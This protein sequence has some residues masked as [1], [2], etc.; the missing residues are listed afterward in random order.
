MLQEKERAVI[1]AGSACTKAAIVAKRPGFILDKALLL[2]PLHAEWRIGQHIIKS[3]FGKTVIFKGAVGFDVI[4]IF[5]FDEHVRTADGISFVVP[6]LPE[7]MRLGITIEVADVLLCHR[8]HASRAAGRVVNRL[9]HMALAQVSFRRKQQIDHQ[10]NYFARCEV[11]SGLLIGLFSSDPDNLFEHITHLHVVN[12]LRRQVDIIGCKFLDDIEEQVL[13]I[14]PV[15]L[16]AK[17]KLLEYLP[18]IGRKCV[19]VAVQV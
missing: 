9:D 19:D 3:G 7:E 6:V 16:D 12:L 13:L 10:F 18:H 8:K 5:T 1:N 2:F 15:D 4:R 11:L 17:V 14:H